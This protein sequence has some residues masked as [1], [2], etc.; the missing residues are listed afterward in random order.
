MDSKRNGEALVQIFVDADA[1]PVVGIIETIAEKYNIPIT[2]LCDTNHILYSNY[3]EVMVVGAGTDAVD[4]KL[5][6]ICHKGDIV[7]SQDYGVAAMALGKGAYAIHQSGKWYTNNNIDQM[8]ME[9]HLNKK[10]RRSSH[11][12]HIKGPKKRTEEDDVRF[13]QS[14]EKM[15]M[16]VQEK[17]QKNTKTKRKS[18]TFYFV[19]HS[20]AI[21]VPD[22]SKCS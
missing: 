19:Y 21:S 11:K 22:T 6:S 17:F 18:M 3:S 2:L 8:R 7:V 9:R 13:A 12:N 10:A 16:M 5:I 20:T 14:F 1:C 15:L 4:Y